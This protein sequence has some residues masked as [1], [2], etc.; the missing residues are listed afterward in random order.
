MA[1]TFDEI[2]D[3]L[4]D[5]VSR[6]G[7]F[8][9]AT[10]PLSGK[11]HVNLSPKGRSARCGSWGRGASPT[12]TWAAVAPRR[13]RT[14]ARTDGSSSCSAPSTARFHGRGTVVMRNE[15]DFDDLL[16][17]GGFQD[18]S[19]PQ[20]RRSIVDV[21]VTR[22][23]DSCGYLV[24]RMSIEGQREHHQLSTAK[25]LRTVG[26]EGT[27]TIASPSTRRASTV[28]RRWAN[29]CRPSADPRAIRSADPHEGPSSILPWT[30]QTAVAVNR[31]PSWDPH[32]G[33]VPQLPCRRH[34]GGP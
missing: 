26:A 4:R 2:T 13:S 32:D 34:A 33:G 8:F 18:A 16:T 21:D 3:P 31:G 10:A 23:S 7:M 30:L 22:V 27:G 11:G 9:V 28:Y 5:W 1:N 12:S 19:L 24:P 25:R 20:A 15:P 17:A 6:Q 29:A 14:C